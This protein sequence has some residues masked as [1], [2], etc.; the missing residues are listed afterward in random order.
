MKHKDL[1][2]WRKRNKYSQSQLAKVL[3][4]DVMTISRW[5]R[6]VRAIPSYLHLALERL[7]ERNTLKTKSKIKRSGGQYG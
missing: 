1:I 3:G 6:G 7:E 4:V 2:T 5:E